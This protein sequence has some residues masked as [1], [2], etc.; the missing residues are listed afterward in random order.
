[1]L[2]G[3]SVSQLLNAE[4]GLRRG[5]DL[6]STARHQSGKSAFAGGSICLPGV[7]PLSA[8]WPMS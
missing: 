7:W 8:S 5:F 1:M 6:R 3:E 4:A 2:G